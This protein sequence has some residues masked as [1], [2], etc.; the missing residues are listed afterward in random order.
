MTGFSLNGSRVTISSEP[1]TS[2]LE[3]LRQK[4]HTVCS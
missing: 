3:V 4:G 2:L 1:S